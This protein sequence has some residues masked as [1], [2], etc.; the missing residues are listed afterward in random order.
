MKGSE[1]VIN[2]SPCWVWCGNK[3]YTLDQQNGGDCNSP[4]NFPGRQKWQLAKY[5]EEDDFWWVLIVRPSN[6][7]K[8]GNS[9][10]FREV[11][12]RVFIDK[13]EYSV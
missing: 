13:G 5:F 10:G 7:P 8:I 2:F 1:K 3:K 9:P 11:K 6:T 12:R 4:C